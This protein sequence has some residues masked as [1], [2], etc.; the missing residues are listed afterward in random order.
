MKKGAESVLNELG[1]TMTQAVKLFLKQVI[2]R[3]A[4]PFAVVVPDKKRAFVSKE[5]ES[6]IEKSL[7][8]ITKGKKVTIDMSDKKQVAKYFGI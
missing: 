5:E 2:M 6:M 8:Q 1:L 3:K 7:V 4:I